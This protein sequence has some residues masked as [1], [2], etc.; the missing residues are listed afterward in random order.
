MK[1]SIYET[2][3]FGDTRVFVV[4]DPRLPDFH[5][6]LV[7]VNNGVRCEAC[8]SHLREKSSSC[9]HAQ[10]VRYRLRKMSDNHAENTP[11]GT[12]EG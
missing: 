7:L 2:T 4:N 12:G 1:Y 11:A 9:E 3:G 10:A 5:Y 8:S 6:A